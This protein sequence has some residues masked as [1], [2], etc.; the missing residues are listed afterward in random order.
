MRRFKQ[1]IFTRVRDTPSASLSLCPSPCRGA[2][3][4]FPPTDNTKLGRAGC[5]FVFHQI[6]EGIVPI[7]LLAFTI[8][9]LALKVGLGPGVFQAHRHLKATAP[10]PLMGGL[11]R[12]IIR[13]CRL[14]ILAP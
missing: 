13:D 12:M 11:T 10:Y 5:V 14:W 8:S 3:S 2:M 7:P 4:Y 9:P 1:C 6:E